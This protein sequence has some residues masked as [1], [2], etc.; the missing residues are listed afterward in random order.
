MCFANS[1]RGA[2]KIPFKCM[3]LMS[4]WRRCPIRG[5]QFG[6][7]QIGYLQL[8]THEIVRQL[9]DKETPTEPIRFENFVIVTLIIIIIIII[10]IIVIIIIYS[11]CTCIMY[12]NRKFLSHFFVY[13]VIFSFT[14]ICHFKKLVSRL[15][16]LF[17]LFIYLFIYLFIFNSG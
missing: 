8:D 17:S 15:Y 11:V 13:P 2:R 6:V 3:C 5:I 9:R 4:E 12:F 16:F 1:R 7:V 10:I 14:G